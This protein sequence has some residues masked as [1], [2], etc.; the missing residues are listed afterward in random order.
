[1]GF[2]SSFGGRFGLPGPEQML[3][4]LAWLAPERILL[5]LLNDAM[6]EVDREAASTAEAGFRLPALPL[7]K[8]ER[9][10][11][12]PRAGPSGGAMN[13]AG[14]RQSSGSKIPGNRPGTKSRSIST[15]RVG[16]ILPVFSF[17]SE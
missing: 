6:P 9:L 11:P 2:A 4:Q 14:G 3:G 8:P 15:G 17:A 12:E 13:R 5:L 10:P 1:V 7:G 16:T